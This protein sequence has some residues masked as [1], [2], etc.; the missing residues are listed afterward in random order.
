MAIKKSTTHDESP[1]IFLHG[2]LT[3]SFRCFVITFKP[4]RSLNVTLK[5]AFGLFLG[6]RGDPSARV[7]ISNEDK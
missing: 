7:S 4:F 1:V 6:G 5:R 3:C 2:E